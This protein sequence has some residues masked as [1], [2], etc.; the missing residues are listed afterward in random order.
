M[1][2]KETSNPE[3]TRFWLISEVCQEDI[4]K[5]DII[6]S[7]NSDHLAIILHFSSISKQKYGPSFWK[8]NASLTDDMNY[9]ALLT[10]SVSEW[11]AEFSAVTDKRVLWDLIKHRIRQFSIKYSKEKAHEKRERVSKIEKMLQTC[12][13]QCSKC[14]SDENFVQLENLQIEYDDIIYMKTWLKAR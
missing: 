9:V 13:E 11:L 1:E 2:T 4:E 10:E 12:E 5:S 7:I 6:S 14:P 3:K 8:F